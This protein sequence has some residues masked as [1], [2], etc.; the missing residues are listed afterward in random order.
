MCRRGAPIDHGTMIDSHYY[1]V[2]L[3]G[4]GPKTGTMRG[5]VDQLPALEVA[6]PPEFGG[7]GGRWSPEHLFVASISACLMTTFMS[8]AENSNLEVLGYSDDATGRLVRAEDRLFLID[9]VVLQPR[10]VIADP[11][12]VDRAERLLEKAERVCLISRSTASKIVLEGKIVV[13]EPVG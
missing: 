10:V 8:I 6:S 13:A 4:N 5:V 11:S 7:P 3:I 9:E 12:Q 1:E 2:S